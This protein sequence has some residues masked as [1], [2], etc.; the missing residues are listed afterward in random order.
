MRRRAFIFGG[1]A[2][3]LAHPAAYG[4]DA[5]RTYRLGILTGTPRTAPAYAALFDELRRAGFIE[6][7]NLQIDNRGIGAYGDEVGRVAKELAASG[8]DAIFTGGNLPARRAQEATR[9]IPIVGINDDMVAEGLVHSLAHPEGNLTGI[10]ILAPE[11]DGKR[12]EL[13]IEAA[14]G[15]RRMAAIADA[16]VTSEAGL[17][18]LQHGARARG[19]ELS[20]YPLRSRE[21]IVPA[22]DAAHAAGAGAV[23]MLATPLVNATLRLIIERMLAL[24]LPAIYQ[25]PDNAE[26]GGLMAYGP[27]HTDVYRQVARLLVKIF[28][29]AKP[30]DLP[31]EQPA[32]F[33]LVVNLKTAQAIGFQ[34]PPSLIERADEVIE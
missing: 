27:R 28:R 6:G 19:V 15:I 18:A 31:I 33:E 13:L 4:Q 3:S 8:V 1:L 7:R 29:G 5:G 23:N 17:Q 34:F 16:N 14:P 22:I 9:T 21:E 26:A 25:W 11:L 2:V 32:K 30:G 20:I 24:K 10:S 12:Q